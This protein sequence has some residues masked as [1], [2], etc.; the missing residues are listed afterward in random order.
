[1]E[2]PWTVKTN[3]VKLTE[4]NDYDWEKISEDPHQKGLHEG[5]QILRN[6]GKVYVIYSCSGSW[7]PT[8]KLAQLSMDENA[9]PMDP[10]NWTKKDTPV[11]TGT[12]TVHGVGHA[13]FTT[14]PDGTENWIVYHSKI[15]TRP[16]WQRNVRMQKFDFTADGAP[17]F[18]QAID[19]GVPLKKPS[20]EKTATGGEHFNDSF[21]TNNWDNWCYYG[22]NRFIN[23]VDGALAIGINPGWGIANNYRSGE[24]AII[25]D[26]VWDDFT[27]QAKVKVV[28]GD[29]DAGLIFRVRHPSVGYDAFKGYF[30]GIIPGSNKAV[31]GK[32]DGANWHELAMKDYPC[33]GNVWYDLKVIADKDLI[34]LFVNGKRVIEIRDSS[35]TKGLAGIR[36]VN[37]HAEFDEV[38]MTAK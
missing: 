17:D 10:K 9:D 33:Q 31:L 2:N 14:S 8:Y 23:V 15:S 19:A 18:G 30:A 26:R 11:L 36:V 5:P 34:K 35:F 3:R 4:N 28:E 6:N 32:I 24:K 27:I 12:K 20:G 29:C 37:T 38:V 16:G 13:S 25:R 21:D 7:E 22:Y 1:M